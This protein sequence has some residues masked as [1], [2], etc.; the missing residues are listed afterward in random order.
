MNTGG[1]G[2]C[3][4]SGLSI[5]CSKNF[6]NTDVKCTDV[7]CFRCDLSVTPVTQFNW[8]KLFEQKDY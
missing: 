3:I 8:I 5:Y 2:I 7:L 1:K 6:S 4:V